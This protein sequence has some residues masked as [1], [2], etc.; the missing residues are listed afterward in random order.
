[1]TGI[2]PKKG[3]VTDKNGNI[4]GQHNGIINYTVG[5][6]KG[7]GIAFGKP[8]YVIGKSAEDNTV[9]VGESEDLY[10]DSLIADELNWI[11]VKG[12]TDSIK[13]KAKTRYSQTE[14]E[15]TIYPYDGSKARVVFNEPQRAVTKGQRVV[16]Y[17]NDTVIGGGVII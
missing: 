16:F 15:C 11:S 2:I 3:N 1:Y 8:M 10:S 12:I 4:L 17:D 5:Q 13:C 6:R 7:L 9:T 14:Q